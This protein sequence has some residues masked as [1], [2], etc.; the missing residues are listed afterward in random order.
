MTMPLPLFAFG[1]VFKGYCC[2]R[3]ASN[4]TRVAPSSL[5]IKFRN[6]KEWRGLARTFF[7]E[8]WEDMG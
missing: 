1:A 3:P 2:F 4:T 6:D 8:K 7:G 5:E